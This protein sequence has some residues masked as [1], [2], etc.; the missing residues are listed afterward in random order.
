MP[1]DKINILVEELAD[2]FTR[3]K[4]VNELRLLLD[5]ILTP[6]E[7]EGIHLRW[8]LLK[9]LA[10]GVTQREIMTRLGICLGKIS[11]GSRLMKY[12]DPGFKELV[13]RICQERAQIQSKDAKE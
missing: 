1:Q 9:L 6:S 2:I 5:G 4:D 12:G 7:I 11:R 10:E 8:A 3:T 13:T